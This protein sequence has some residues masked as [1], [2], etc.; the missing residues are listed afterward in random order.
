MPDT[1]N[2][3]PSQGTGRLVSV[4]VPVYNGARYLSESLDSALAQDYSGLEVVVVDDGSTDDTP[5]ILERYVQRHGGRV[6]GIRQANR[7]AAAARNAALLAA[8]GE[9]IAFLDAD[10]LWAPNKVGI[11]VRH[12][13]RHPDV[14]L[15]YSAWTVVESTAAAARARAMMADTSD[16]EIDE[17]GSGWLYNELLTDCLLHTTTVILRRR[18]LESVG[19]FDAELRRGQDYDYWL[20][21][22]RVTRI[23]KLRS[24]LSIYRLHDSNSTSQPLRTNYSGIVV[25]RAVD[26]WGLIGPDG[27]TTPTAV[28][29]ARLA[30]SW[31]AFGYAH[32]RAGNR[33]VALEAFLRSMRYRPLQ[34]RV[35]ALALVTA[36][37]GLPRLL[38]WR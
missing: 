6:R 16:G 23:H 33:L 7:G 10:D 37:P 5:A 18:L 21:A 25:Q 32:A 4:I 2:S 22:S 12:L 1:K 20:R 19:L 24:A 35:L 26:R 34:P 27:R 30:Q 9:Y 13:E 3:S 17:A 15:V 31:S 36:T 14:D 38:G 8:R 11:Q 28:V 29:R